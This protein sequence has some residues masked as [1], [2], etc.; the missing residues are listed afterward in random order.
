MDRPLSPAYAQVILEINH[1]NVDKTFTYHIPPHLRDKVTLG[2][3]VTLP[4]G[5]GNKAYGGY[6]VGFLSHV[7]FETKDLLG[8]QKE[9]ALLSNEMI[10][11]ALWMKD[12]YYTTMASCLKVILPS[13]VVKTKPKTQNFVTLAPDAGAVTKKKPSASGQKVIDYLTQQGE[14]SQVQLLDALQISTSPLLTLHKQGVVHIAAKAIDRN[15]I[16]RTAPLTAPKVLNEE[17]RQAVDFCLRKH[18]SIS[19]KPILIHG[20]T[21]SGKTEVYMELI[22]RV[23]SEGKQAI[24]LVPEISLTPQTVSRF[25]ARFGPLV[26]FTH[27]RL[28]A[29]ERTD[30]WQKAKNGDIS[31]MIG[32]RS[33]VFTPFEQLGIIIIDEE[34][35]HT[36]RS[37]TTPKYDA[38]EVAIQRGKLHHATVVF[39][40]ATPSILTYFNAQSHRYD[41]VSLKRRVNQA[42]PVIHVIDMRQELVLGNTSIFSLP[43]KQAILSNLE[44]KRQTILFLNRRGHSTFVSCRNCGHVMDC[45]QCNVNY[46]YH[47]FTNKL[48]CHYC[49][50]EMD[51]PTNCPTCGS[52]FIRHF[53]VG[54]QRVEKELETLFPEARILRMDLD[55]TS[56]KHAHED[57]LDQFR[58]GQADILIGTQMI[59]KGLDFPNV[60]LVGIIAADVSLNS[61]DYQSGENTYALLTQVAGRAG[62]AKDKGTVYIQTYNPEHYSVTATSQGT[63]EDFYTQEI[64]L[65]RQGFYPPFS[66]VFLIVFSGPREKELIEALFALLHIMNHY[67][68]KRPIF[69]ML[70][71]APAIISKVKHQYRWKLIVK[72]ED[73]DKLKNFVS[74]TLKKLEQTHPTKH[75]NINLTLNP[76]VII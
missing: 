30:Q 9:G 16:R 17:Q 3:C 31:I 10:Q 21:G 65:R 68:V 60:T 63:Y 20:V 22:D 12:K 57:L 32:P 64:A 59:A 24:V 50:D 25:V 29:G 62:R 42:P 39:G 74:Y 2:A 11:L 56:K 14:V 72:C 76:S 75:L 44:T 45:H 41:L 15:P 1:K 36:Y 33:A 51:N 18:Q 71:P 35:E 52:K 37:E 69:E 34:H 7:D 46:T 6:V 55:T 48:M 47:Q 53:G 5:R 54:T 26:N 73:E 58:S 40:S 70:G 67:T 49:A 27:S 38:L 61:G 66:H 23:L 19:Q 28:S 8:L 13:G 43:L 4:F